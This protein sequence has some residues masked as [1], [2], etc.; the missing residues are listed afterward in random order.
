M[1]TVAESKGF[2]Y[3]DPVFD[4][5]GEENM[6]ASRRVAIKFFIKVQ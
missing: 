3:S 5:N 2:S 4:E 6:D 1:E